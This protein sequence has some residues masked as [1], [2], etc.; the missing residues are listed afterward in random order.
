[1]ESISFGI[2]ECNGELSLRKELMRLSALDSNFNKIDEIVVTASYEV[3][4][5]DL[6]KYKI[7]IKLSLELK[8]KNTSFNH[9]VFSKIYY[10]YSMY[11]IDFIITSQLTIS[12]KSFYNTLLDISKVI[13]SKTENKVKY[14]SIDM[15]YGVRFNFDNDFSLDIYYDGGDK[16]NYV[17][18][19]K[20]IKST[21]KRIY[22]L[23]KNGIKILSFRDINEIFENVFNN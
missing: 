14:Y 17:L 23:A 22:N 3:N 21:P 20:G 13:Y 2:Q 12:A 19:H 5:S 15:I 8:A 4:E 9:R 6:T 16:L 1:M 11:S 10:V 7:P 18:I